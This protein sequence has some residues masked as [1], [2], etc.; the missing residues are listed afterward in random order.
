MSDSEP[1]LTAVVAE[2][3]YPLLFLA[4]SGAHLYGFASTDS[5]YDLRGVHILPAD[6]VLSLRTPRETIERSQRRGYVDIDLVTHDAR[7]FFTMML[8]KNGYVL[9]QLFS[10]LV[11]HTTPEHEELR[12]IGR[13][14]VTRHHVHHYRSFAANQWDMFAKESPGR[15][16]PLLYV[17]RVLL[18]G[19]HLMRTG[20]VESNLPRLNEG[21]RLSHVDELIA[22]K[23]AG[24]ERE[25]LG[26]GEVGLHEAEYRRLMQALDEAAAG[27]VLPEESGARDALSD[28]LVRIRRNAR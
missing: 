1:R 9:E 7:K 6:E 2:Q 24:V 22:R 18:T 4:F 14:C 12:A 13:G 28:L 17:Y 21:F 27:T 26:D 23:R 11:V 25:V 5:D 20:E 15:I 10:P 16:K 19:I 3:P 8:K